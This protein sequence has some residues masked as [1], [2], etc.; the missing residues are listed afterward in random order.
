MH[1]ARACVKIIRIANS[2]MVGFAVLVGLAIVYGREVY[3]LDPA[4][5]TLSYLTGFFI[6]ASSMI[7]NDIVDIEIDKIN[8][9]ERPLVKG[10]ITLREAWACYVITGLAGLVASAYI[11]FWSLIVALSGWIVGSLYDAWG[12]KSGFP[13]NV[14]VAF[15]TSLPFP[16]ALA[17]AG[18]L[19]KTILVY[20][21][22]VFLTVLGREIIKDIADVTGDKAAGV[23]SLPI[24]LGA[25]SAAKIASIFYISAVIL[26][27]LPVIWREVKI[28]AYLPLVAI[29][30][31]ILVYESIKI[32]LEPSKDVALSSKKRVLF[33]MLLGLIAFLLAGVA[34]R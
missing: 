27:P 21:S 4:I 19:E 1:K 11:G 15:A 6:S 24:I 33:A 18:V 2:L 26:S 34:G 25:H 13:G 9:P 29:V 20:W 16:Y 8:Q 10:D 23:K 5:L 32:I 7:L 17:V 30:D 3:R 14:M 22:M 28:E 12:K 31:I